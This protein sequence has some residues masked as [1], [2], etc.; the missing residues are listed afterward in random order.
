MEGEFSGGVQI[1]GTARAVDKYSTIYEG[2]IMDGKY[3]GHGKCTYKDGTYFVGRF[4]KGS[5]RGGKHYSATGK[6]LKVLSD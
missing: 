3:H 5:R 2:E 1:N 6:L 4:E